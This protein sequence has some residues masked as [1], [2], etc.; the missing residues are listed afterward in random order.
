MDPVYGFQAVNVEAQQSEPSSLLNWMRRM[1]GVRK[2]HKAFGRG[3]L[4]FLYPR[5]RKILAYVRSYEDERILCVANLSRQAQAV[6]LDLSE[7]R[8]PVPI[9]LTGGAAFPPIGDLPYMLTLPAYGF[10]WFLL[11]AEAE[12]PRWHQPA[13]DPLPEF[14]TLTAAGGRID[15][16]LGGRERQQLE[17]DAL[18]EFL[19][20]QR[21]FAGKSGAIRKV[22]VTPLARAVGRAEP[23]RHR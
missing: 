7:C 21:W 1:I 5:N 10:F 15:D 8:G 23:P 20:R 14:V 16:A 19:A 11:A 2:Q 18:P 17:R 3:T 4:S 9:E 12:A 22:A 6:E 13:P